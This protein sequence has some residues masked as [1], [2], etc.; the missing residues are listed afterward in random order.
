[1][2]EPERLFHVTR[3]SLLLCMYVHTYSCENMC[4]C[5]RLRMCAYVKGEGRATYLVAAKRKCALKYSLTFSMNLTFA[6]QIREMK[7]ASL[8]IILCT[9]SKSDLMSAAMSRRCGKCGSLYK[10]RQT[11]IRTF[12][13]K[14]SQRVKK[15][16]DTFQQTKFPDVLMTRR[17]A[18]D[19]GR[20]LGSGQ[21][22]KIPV[23]YSHDQQ[24]CANG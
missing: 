17:Q 18:E 21:P 8:C 1:M 10:I 12:H 3:C 15:P 24:K 6:T 16:L 20:E 19:A 4:A 7:Y 14:T 9:A 5:V 22:M 2:I 11:Q 23:W 13:S